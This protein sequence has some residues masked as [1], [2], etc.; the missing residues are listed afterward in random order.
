MCG[1]IGAFSDTLL[2]E[3]RLVSCRASQAL[4]YARTYRQ[5]EPSRVYIL[6]AL[7]LSFF[8]C[9]CSLSASYID[10]R[11]SIDTV[12]SIDV[13]IDATLCVPMAPN[14]L[15]FLCIMAPILMVSVFARYV[16]LMSVFAVIFDVVFLKPNREHVFL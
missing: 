14:W 6:G 13:L 11:Y 12:L 2:A 1:H 4:P 9:Q 10:I 8:S 15:N 7:L 5:F 16:I 3:V